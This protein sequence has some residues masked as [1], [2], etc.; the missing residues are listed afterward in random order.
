MRVFQG[1]RVRACA[2]RPVTAALAFAGIVGLAATARGQETVGPV[3]IHAF[4]TIVYGKTDHNHYAVGSPEGDYDHGL[5]AVMLTA[6]ATERLNIVTK[7][8]LEQDEEG[9]SPALDY[10]FG[11]WR[12]SDAVKF[13]AGRVKPPF[14]L[15]AEIFDVGTLR[16]FVILPQGIY[17]PSGF[18]SEGFDGLALTGRVPAGERWALEYDVYGGSIKF[19]AEDRSEDILNDGTLVAVG[20]RLRAV[21]GGR[22]NV[23]TP[24]TG[25]IVGVSAYTGTEDAG[26]HTAVAVHGEYLAD[27]WSLR[28]EFAHLGE[29]RGVSTNAFYLEAARGLGK[30]QVA[31]RYDSSQ[32]AEGA[33]DL[34]ESLGRH[35]DTSLGVNYW[36][37]SGFVLKLSYHHVDGNRFAHPQ[38][39]DL[40]AAVREGRLDRRTDMAVFGAQF[41][42]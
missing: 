42:F 31:V 24:K 30:W 28:S 8:A 38:G 34:A 41:S 37:A 9:I 3:Q 11:E 25:L 27:P 1:P 40:I 36:F 2:F 35:R 6:H 17:G 19:S 4:G 14:G 21:I 10:A 13:R 23:E 12:F 5:L 26:R 39:E 15:Y 18:V 16:P 32:T 20:D 33:A 7:F 22:L 29:A